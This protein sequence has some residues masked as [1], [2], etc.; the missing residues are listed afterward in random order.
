MPIL[1]S[2]VLLIHKGRVSFGFPGSSVDKES[3]CKVKINLSLILGLRR[4]PGEGKGYPPQYSGVENS[5]DCVVH[6]VTKSR[7]QLSNFHK[8]QVI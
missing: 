7:T 3:A 5:M 8:G 6:G 2:Q 4:P 1:P